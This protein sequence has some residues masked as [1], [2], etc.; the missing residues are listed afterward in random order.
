[1]VVQSC[2]HQFYIDPPLR[3]IFLT[4]DCLMAI[5]MQ[6]KEDIVYD[7]G[8]LYAGLNW[9]HHLC[10]GMVEGGGNVLALQSAVF[11]NS[12][13]KDFASQSYDFWINTLL[14][15]GWKNTLDDLKSVLSI[16]HF[17][18]THQSLCSTWKISK[19]MQRMIWMLLKHIIFLDIINIF[20]QNIKIIIIKFHKF[21]MF[22]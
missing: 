20:D 11:L 22:L 19:Q 7:G 8:Q 2:S 15:N 12:C 13:L 5:M 10:Q 6:P 18:I 16:L 14:H 21:N 3:H 17:Q 4:I 1:M 9:C